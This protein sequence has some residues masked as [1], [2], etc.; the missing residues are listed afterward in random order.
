[1]VGL[2]AYVFAKAV[3]RELN[4]KLTKVEEAGYGKRSL[5]VC[6]ISVNTLTVE[7]VLRHS[8]G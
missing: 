4:T 7:K 2:V 5:N 8:L 1:V 6:V 3:N